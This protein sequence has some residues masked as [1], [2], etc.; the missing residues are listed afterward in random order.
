MVTTSASCGTLSRTTGWV[1]SRLAAMAGSA[2]LAPD[3]PGRALLEGWLTRKPDP[4]LLT[5]WTHLIQGLCQQ[6]SREDA[7]ALKAGLLE[8]ARAVAGSSGGFLGM[9]SKVS[10]AEADMIKRLDSAFPADS[11]TSLP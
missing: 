2:E 7:A 10:V 4:K 3:S 5:A 9:G 1:V 8:R 6:L 11:S